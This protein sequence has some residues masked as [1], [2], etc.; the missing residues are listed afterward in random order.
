MN[1]PASLTL[2]EHLLV[3]VKEWLDLSGH[4]SLLSCFDCL[5]VVCSSQLCGKLTLDCKRQ[6]YSYFQLCIKT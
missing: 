3:G 5:V 1:I 4:F 6:R 2:C